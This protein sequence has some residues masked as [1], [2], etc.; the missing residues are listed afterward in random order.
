MRN[1]ETSLFL[2]QPVTKIPLMI[3][4]I[5]SSK[6]FCIID[7]VAYRINPNLSTI[8]LIIS[9]KIRKPSNQLYRYG[10][11]AWQT[12]PL[13]EGCLSGFLLHPFCV[14]T[15]CASIIQLHRDWYVFRPLNVATVWLNLVLSF[16]L[17]SFRSAS[18]LYSFIFP[19]VPGASS[20]L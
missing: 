20:T 2:D 13:K 19:A 3:S 10:W 12:T 11:I 7:A 9:T 18:L 14:Y 1:K 16:Y 6:K 17:T 8:Y 15:N 5:I 4:I